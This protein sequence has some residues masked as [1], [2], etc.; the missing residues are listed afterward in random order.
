MPY[1]A[2]VRDATHARKGADSG[3]RPWFHRRI[4]TPTLITLAALATIALT[5]AAL[6]RWRRPG[7]L[8][9]EGRTLWDWLSLLAVPLV[10]GFATV[11]INAGQ[12]QLANERAAEA[13][14]QQ[15]VDR[16]S[17]LVIDAPAGTD[18]EARVTAIGR[19]QT[20]AALRLVDRDRAGRVLAF[21]ADMDLL[22]RFAI[23]LEGMQLDGAE[24]KGLVLAGMDFENASLRSADLEG[25]LLA[26]ADFEGAD[27]ARADFKGADLRGVDFDAARLSGTEFDGA[28]LRGAVLARASGLRARQLAR[29]CMDA[30]TALPAGFTPVIGQSPGCALDPAEIDDD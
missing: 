12:Q 21:L 30:T 4:M 28:D 29:A 8:G 11:L 25:A 23:S 14:L 1:T 27:L 17:A 2:R 10:V 20:L 6:W 5:L 9:F 18:A 13:A 7:W 22:A 24:L 19:A 15:Y 3:A 16:I 26:G